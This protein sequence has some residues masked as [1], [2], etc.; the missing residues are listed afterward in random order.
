MNWETCLVEEWEMESLIKYNHVIEVKGNPL[1]PNAGVEIHTSTGKRYNAIYDAELKGIRK[2]NT[3]NP[4]FKDMQNRDLV[5]YNDLLANPSVNTI[6]VDGFFGT[7]KTSTVSAHLIHGLEKELRNEEGICKAYISKPH[8]GIGQGYGYLPGDLHA[9]TLE[10]FKSFTQYFDRFG[11]PG[12]ADML[13]M[14]SVEEESRFTKQ[15]VADFEE[16]KGLVAPMLEILPFE[17]LRGR[18]IPEGWV[19]LDEAQNTNEAEMASFV[20]RVGDDAKMIILGDSTST[21][22]D[23][24]GNTSVKNGLAFAKETFADKKYAGYVELQSLSHI[25]R[26]ERVRDLLRHM[27]KMTIV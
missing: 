21:Q 7:G 20:S 6:I 1:T 26:G 10:E 5:L 23:R 22:I 18:D 12:F 19:I 15:R 17:Y 11:S 2:L 9:K 4:Q 14:R 24:R 16:Q 13:L 27:K 8:V 3:D 25:L